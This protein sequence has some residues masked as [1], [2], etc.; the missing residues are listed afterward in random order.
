MYTLLCNNPTVNQTQHASYKTIGQ[1]REKQNIHRKCRKRVHL[2][3]TQC[4]SIVAK[5][6]TQTLKMAVPCP[7]LSLPHIYQY[8]PGATMS[9]CCGGQT[10]LK[11]V[12]KNLFYFSPQFSH[13][14]RSCLFLNIF[15][16]VEVPGNNMFQ[17][18][19]PIIT[20]PSRKSKHSNA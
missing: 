15:I 20:H 1:S 10:G 4:L 16:D 17:Q 12:I 18:T 11:A 19:I 5:A 8:L 9:L 2:W 7:L 14:W 3:H 13:K 6:V